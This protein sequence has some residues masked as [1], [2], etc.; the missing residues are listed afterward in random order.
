VT[1]QQDAQIGFK[2]ESVWATPVTPDVFPEYVAEDL[3]WNPQF[4]QGAGLKVGRRVD[5]DSR[6][7]LVKDDVGGSFTVEPHTKGLGRLI[8]AALG[9]TGASTVASTPAYQQLF[10]PTSTDDLSSY[11]IQKGL[12]LVGGGASQPMTFAGMVCSGFELQAGNGA[13]PTLKF[14]WLGKAVDTS[15]GLATASYVTDDE[16]FSF[17]HASLTLGG[18]VTPPSTTA[19]AS[20][21]TAANDI[22]EFNLTY[23]NGLDANGWNMGS[24]G[25]RTRKPKLGK[26]V[27]TGSFVA[28]FDATTI[29]DLYLAR[30]STPLVFTLTSLNAITGA[31]Y[32]AFQICLPAIKLDGELPKTN[33]G[34]VVTLSVGFTIY[35]NGTAA[36]PVYV[37]IVTTETSI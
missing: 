33:G 23:S 19:L 35:D 24:T 10:T 32:P 13:I 11:T 9:G 1:T 22:R 14:N 37:A 5:A 25:K 30:T 21:G 36:H 16:L 17:I 2:K 7:V 27:I 28:E 20:G 34:D 12:P 6:N 4:A 15:T 31:Y 8:E 26:R 29:R 3:D 18:S